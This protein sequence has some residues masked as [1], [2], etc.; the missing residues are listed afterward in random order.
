MRVFSVRANVDLQTFFP[1]DPDDPRDTKTLTNG[2]FPLDCTPRSAQWTP[3]PLY[4]Q[5]QKSKRGN[6][7]F[8]WS[9]NIAADSR[10]CKALRPVFDRTCE[11][12]PMLPYDGEVFHVMNV[13]EC[14]DCL[15]NEKTKWQVDQKTGRR[16]QIEEY[17]FV[18]ERFAESTLFKLPKRRVLLTV[19]GLKDLKYDFKSI[20]EREGLTGLE[21][22]ELWS[23]TGPQPRQ[24]SFLEE[25]LG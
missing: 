21:F 11:F 22:E 13:L 17:S 10:A 3:L 12:L 14:V 23:D 7:I 24:K 9:G 25:I 6:F 18:P 20:V 19:T 4:A 16:L 5:N 15:D 1:Y 8:L 2:M